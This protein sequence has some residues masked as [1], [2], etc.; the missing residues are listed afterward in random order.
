MKEKIEALSDV[1]LLQLAHEMTLLSL[2]V[3][4]LTRKI[5]P[6]DVGSNFAIKL[7]EISGYLVQVMAQRIKSYSPYLNL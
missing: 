6:E 1:E 2:P 4:A 7:I 5:M 3:D